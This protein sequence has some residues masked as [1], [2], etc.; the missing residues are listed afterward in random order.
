[1]TT[2]E[3]SA[4][5]EE[6]ATAW[7]ARLDR[8]PLGSEEEQALQG[9]L[10]GDTRRLGAFARAQAT[11]LR[12]EPARALGDCYDP[13]A[14]LRNAGADGP[15]LHDEPPSR[16]TRRRLLQMG[17]G[18]AALGM[19]GAGYFFSR[20]AAVDYTSA[21]E[22]IRRVALEDGSVIHLN[23]ASAITVRFTPEAR[24]VMLK[25]GE[26]L[27]DVARDATR[28]FIVQVGQTS[29]RALETVFSVRRQMGAAVRVMVRKGLVEVRRGS[30][31]GP[32]LDLRAN[33]LAQ[34][35]EDRSV[36]L[37]ID[38][39]DQG[40]HGVGGGAD[41]GLSWLEG[42]LTFR[43]TRLADAAEEFAR[44]N[45]DRT[46][47]LDPSLRDHRISGAFAADDPD[48]FAQAVATSYGLRV[49]HGGKAIRIL[50]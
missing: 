42:K 22:T 50:P 43:G 35:D 4:E 34:V 21:G 6:A 23:V 26:V 5:I 46:I 41:N 16:L 2:R 48:G 40:D 7:L 33:M 39:I 27:F 28:P 8:A 19:L 30:G 29:L 15:D 3:T 20:S 1:M 36:P 45:G 44:Y 18:G 10:A 12:L 17:G 31:E 25:T 47:L 11:M 38:R 37:R 13:D 14:F 9:W 49:E 24:L 32:A